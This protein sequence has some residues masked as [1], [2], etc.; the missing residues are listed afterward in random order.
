[1]SVNGCVDCFKKCIV[2]YGN[3]ILEISMY[4]EFY[5]NDII[6]R[7]LKLDHSKHFYLVGCL[8]FKDDQRYDINSRENKDCIDIKAIVETYPYD[9]G[10]IDIY[11]TVMFIN[12]EYK[13]HDDEDLIIITD[14]LKHVYTIVFKNIFTVQLENKHRILFDLY[15][16]YV[17]GILKN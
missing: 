9:F 13:K 3:R 17:C 11:M 4:T 16:D 12:K 7:F 8:L 5:D 1:M 14:I 6:I 15:I 2:D 10:D